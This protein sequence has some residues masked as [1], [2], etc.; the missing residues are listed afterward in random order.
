LLTGVFLSHQIP[1]VGRE[2]TCEHP[3]SHFRDCRQD[4]FDQKIM[5]SILLVG[6]FVMCFVSAGHSQSAN[7]PSNASIFESPYDLGDAS[8]DTFYDDETAEIAYRALGA[9]T[10]SIIVYDDNR[11]IVHR[12]TNLKNPAGVIIVKPRV[13]KAGSYS[14]A[15]EVNGRIGIRKKLTI[16]DSTGRPTSSCDGKRRRS[17]CFS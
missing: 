17:L 16:L 8:P 6:I 4:R 7:H 2:F 10:F 11:K 5:R 14:Y 12:Y 15:L 3:F 13:L 1:A 9:E